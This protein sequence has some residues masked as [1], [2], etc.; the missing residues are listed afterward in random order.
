MFPVPSVTFSRSKVIL[1]FMG[2][3]LET[4]T[5]FLLTMLKHTEV[6]LV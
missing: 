2:P 4:R 1:N 6:Q 3:L 5:Y